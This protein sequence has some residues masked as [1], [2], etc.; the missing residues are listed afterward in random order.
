LD[1]RRL[2]PAQLVV[3]DRGRRRNDDPT[4]I[5]FDGCH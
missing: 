2:T 4:V 3:I 1:D 5:G